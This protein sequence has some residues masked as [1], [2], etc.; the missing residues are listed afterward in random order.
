MAHTV[1]KVKARACVR[2]R[3]FFPSLVAAPALRLTSFKYAHYVSCGVFQGPFVG[4]S[5]SV[6]VVVNFVTA[7]VIFFIGLAICTYPL[8]GAGRRTPSMRSIIRSFVAMNPK[9][10]Q[11]AWFIVVRY[12]AV[13]E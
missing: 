3:N 2:P 6:V 11:A 4:V 13:F 5:V 9:F 7:R 8:E 10:A 1:E 12:R